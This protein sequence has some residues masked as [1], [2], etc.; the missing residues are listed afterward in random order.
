MLTIKNM[1]GGHFWFLF[2]F[3]FLQI[4][5]DFFFPDV[6]RSYWTITVVFILPHSDNGVLGRAETQWG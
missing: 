4:F 3:V 2:C 6:K 5:S 1:F